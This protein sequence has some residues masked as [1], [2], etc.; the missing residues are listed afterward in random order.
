M[1]PTLK[2]NMITG[3]C[4]PFVR[5]QFMVHTRICVMRQCELGKP[6]HS[7]HEVWAMYDKRGAKPGYAWYFFADEAAQFEEA[8]D[9]MV[10]LMDL[11]ETALA[12][13]ELV[14]QK[15][16]PYFYLAGHRFV[17]MVYNPVCSDVDRK[18]TLFVDYFSDAA[19]FCKTH[20]C[21][22][23]LSDTARNNTFVRNVWDRPLCGPGLF[24]AMHLCRWLQRE[25][26]KKHTSMV[27]HNGLRNASIVAVCAELHQRGVTLG[28][29]EQYPKKNT[30]DYEDML[31]NMGVT[32]NR[33]A[34]RMYA[35]ACNLLRE[36]FQD[37]RRNTYDFDGLPAPWFIEERSGKRA[38]IS[39]T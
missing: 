14:A 19:P 11:D 23:E 36:F 1:F 6:P 3:V 25:D 20:R 21:F 27:I 8:P 17:C 39:T 5:S 13:A 2:T 38:R 30:K 24:V 4:V 31:A 15:Q 18:A 22:Y 10:L 9:A 32:V 12:Q 35:S 29:C 26:K 34:H 16:A 33:E 37:V 28:M 7:D